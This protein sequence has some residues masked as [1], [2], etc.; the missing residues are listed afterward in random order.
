MDTTA[1]GQ[2]EE[3]FWEGLVLSLCTYTEEKEGGGMMNVQRKWKKDHFFMTFVTEN[4]FKMW[5][6]LNIVLSFATCICFY[7]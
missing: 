3:L 4:S 5:I 2:K 6:K 7:L 1:V